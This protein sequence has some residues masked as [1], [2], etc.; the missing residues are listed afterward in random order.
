MRPPRALPICRAAIVVGCV[1]LVGGALTTVSAASVP[2]A[3]TAAGTTAAT[4]ILPT[5]TSALA[6]AGKSARTSAGTVTVHWRGNGHGHGLSQYGAH[7]AAMKGLSTAQI[8]AFYFPG[9]KLTTIAAS[10][11]RVRLSSATAN[12]T[13]FAGTAGLA[14]S[15]FGTLPTKGYTQFR[16]VPAGAGLRLDG[17]KASGAWATVKKGLPARADFRSTPGWVQVLFADGSSTRYRGTVGAVRS[18]ASELT[19]NRVSLDQYVQG[20]VPR[21]MPISWEPAA[22]HAQAVAARSYAESVRAYSGDDLYDICDTPSC[23]V[24]GGMAHYDSAGSLLWTD[25]PQAISGNQNMVLRYAGQ[26]VFAQ[27]SASNGG[28]T[29]DGGRPY[30][31]GRTDP[32]D[33]AAS[34]DPYLDESTSVNL[35]TVAGNLGLR[36]MSQLTGVVRDGHGP[37]GGRV[38]SA[39]VVGTD[40]AGKAKTLAVDGFDLGYAMGVGTDYLTVD[41]PAS[42]PAKPTSVRATP[43][44]AGAQVSWAPPSG[45]TG[46]A[47]TGYRVTARGVTQVLPATARS[48]WVGP[49]NNVASSSVSVRAV[50]AAGYGPAV[51]VAAH[52]TATARGVVPLPPARIVDT[53]TARAVVDPTHPYR[54]TVPG[55]GGVPKAGATSVQLSVTVLNPSR[56]GVLRIGPVG[57]L[58]QPLAAIAYVTGHTTTATVSVPLQP[59]GA[60][61]FTPSA[62]TV[63]LV[64]D[65]QAY[66]APAGSKL[67]VTSPQP[68][69]AISDVSTTSGTLLDL[70]ANKSVA[71]TAKGVVLAIDAYGSSPAALTVWPDGSVAP[72]VRHVTVTPYASGTNTIIVPLSAGHRLRIRASAP[73]VVARVQLVGVLGA[74]GG[75]LVAYPPSAIADGAQTRTVGTTAVP[76]RV[77]GV[78]QVPAAGATAVLVHLTIRAGAVAGQLWA[79]PTGQPSPAA[80]VLRFGANGVSTATALVT[81]GADGTVTLRSSVPG[82]RVAVDSIGY[83]T[84]R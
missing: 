11:I 45:T 20:S 50:N 4:T 64:A 60:I 55:L 42:L 62:G 61:A 16:L 9:T 13:V 22:Y 57:V 58:A 49:L 39:K 44:D 24:Y 78:N 12:T 3:A 6:P 59:T 70:S 68:V 66:S 7:G 33:T 79:Y 82:L 46:A 52:G 23:Q 40:Y 84:P 31:I 25:A 5:A 18:G 38:L 73:G 37:W 74:S 72:A 76:V 36:S 41:T 34:G 81:P 48:L 63:Q 67:L 29:V 27:Y 21:E 53:R 69:A 35:A 32:Y 83:A 30:L 75:G 8:L 51:T 54:V 43:G 17:R 80:P 65:Q 56:S 10:T 2:D 26:P 19:V 14:L 71:A 47:I 15:G 28:A 77:A 1:A